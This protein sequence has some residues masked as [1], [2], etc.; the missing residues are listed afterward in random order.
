MTPKFVTPT[1]YIPS[2]FISADEVLGGKV[3]LDS[4]DAMYVGVYDASIL[5]RAEKLLEAVN[6]MAKFG[7]RFRVCL[8]RYCIMEKEKQN[9]RIAMGKVGV[10]WSARIP[11]CWIR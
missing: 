11:G 7:W 9:G 3:D 10:T 1:F 6:H 8:D 2:F 5:T 4:L